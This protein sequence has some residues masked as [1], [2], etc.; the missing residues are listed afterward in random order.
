MFKQEVDMLKP[1][2]RTHEHL[3]SLLMTWS[4][5]GNFYMLFPWAQCDLSDFWESESCAPPWAFQPHVT[6]HKTVTWMSQQVLGLADAME[7]LHSSSLTSTD[8]KYG[9]HGDIKPENILWYHNPDGERGTLVLSDFGSSTLNTVNSRSNLTADRAAVTLTYRP[10]ECDL[11]DGKLSR[12]SDIWSF[13]C[14]LLELI[15]W[16]LGGADLVH[17]FARTRCTPY[18]TGVRTDAFHEALKS[19]SG[20]YLM[21]IKP[22]VSGVSSHERNSTLEITDD[23][24][25]HSR[26]TSQPKLHRIFSGPSRCN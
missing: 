16:A 2:S 24:P 7:K 25:V 20:G 12:A 22:Q 9:R 10:P 3:V 14:V 5:E 6:F 4:H 15:T 13:G 11:R 17:K 21:R 1:L 19:A 8:R 23:F 26:L 18:I